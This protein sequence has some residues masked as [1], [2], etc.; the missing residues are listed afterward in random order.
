MLSLFLVARLHKPLSKLSLMKMNFC[1]MSHFDN[2][3][4]EMPLNQEN[5]IKKE[6]I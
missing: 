2:N 5:S 3:T 6:L 1:I 4:I